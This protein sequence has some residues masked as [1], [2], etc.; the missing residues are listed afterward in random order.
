MLSTYKE[1]LTKLIAVK[2]VLTKQL[3]EYEGE[4]EG[5][6]DDLCNHEEAR[7]LFQAAATATQKQ[8]EYKLGDV[9]SKALAAIWSDPYKFKVEFTP[10]RGTTECDLLFERNGKTMKPFDSSGYGA[11]DIASLALRA[12]Y[13]A[14]NKSRPCMI[15]DEPCKNL[16]ADKST[17]A[18]TVFKKLSEKFNLQFIMVTHNAGIASEADKIFNIYKSGS[19][20]KVS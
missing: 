7:E 1:K 12:S 20:S 18:S 9:V 13:W 15:F 14:G 17:M 19:E 4:R 5:I 11:A 16:S 8:L 2:D 3:K 10:R 6:R